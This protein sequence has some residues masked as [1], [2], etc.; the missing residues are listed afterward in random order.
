VPGGIVR[1][2]DSRMLAENGGHVAFTKD[3]A[4]CLFVCMNYIK[5]KSSA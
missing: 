3:W 4:H 5:R 1:R 2:R